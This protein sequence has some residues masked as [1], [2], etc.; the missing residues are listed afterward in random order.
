MKYTHSLRFKISRLSVIPLLTVAFLFICI[1]FFISNKLVKDNTISVI[2]SVEQT[3]DGF[4]NEWCET[5]LG[6][7]KS[8]AN[9]IPDGIITAMKSGDAQT[10]ADLSKLSFEATNCD[11]MTFTDME[12]NALCRVTNPAKFGDNIKSSL[13]IAD[14]MEGKSVVYPYPT[15]NNGFSVAAGTPIYENDTQ[16]G[17]L[18]LSKRLDKDEFIDKLKAMTFCEI[19]LYQKDVLVKSS[20]C[21]IDENNAVTLDSDTWQKVYSGKSIDADAKIDGKNAMVRYIPIY[22]KNNEVVGAVKAQFILVSTTWV[23][24][25]WIIFIIAAIV[26]YTPISIT[27]I[28]SFVKPIKKLTDSA[29]QLAIGNINT[30]LAHDRD[31]ELGILQESFIKIS[32]IMKSQ[33]EILDQV[34]HGNLNVTYSA[35]SNVDTVGLSLAAMISNNREIISEISDATTQVSSASGHVSN[36]SQILANGAAEQSDAIKKISDGMADIGDKSRENVELAHNATKLSDESR[37]LMSTSIENMSSLVGAMNDISKASESISKVI[38]VIDDIAFQTNILALNAAVEAARAGAAGKGFAVVA[39]EVRNLAAKSAEAAKETSSIIESNITMVKLGNSI[40]EKS[41]ESLGLLA[42]NSEK[43]NGIVTVI[44]DSSSNQNIL[45]SDLNKS[46]EMVADVIETN[47]STAESSAA[48][49]EELSSQAAI[50]HDL[51]S[52]YQL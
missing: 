12:G 42:E 51:V 6:F 47:S 44:A 38:K 41:N 16:I 17:V 23:T 35:R 19:E 49:S 14:A 46:V 10:I 48:A 20:L 22:G 15:S 31:D 30:D 27:N 28:T 26:I 52:R 3:T 37:E 43:I 2:E 39:E 45:L 32:D 11:G 9:N 1:S 24:I 34:A 4:I 18:F 13:A 5:T 36:D 25:L 21:D 29:E 33:A 50:L 8:Y 7:A 40:V